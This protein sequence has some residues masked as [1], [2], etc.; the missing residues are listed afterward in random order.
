MGL[1]CPCGQNSDLRHALY[2]D[3]PPR[4]DFIICSNRQLFCSRNDPEEADVLAEG[5]AGQRSSWRWT[6]P[7]CLSGSLMCSLPHEFKTP[8]SHYFQGC[9]WLPLSTSGNP[10]DRIETY[11]K[12]H[13]IIILDSIQD[14]V[15]GGG[16]KQ[17]IPLQ[18]QSWKYTNH[19]SFAI[20]AEAGEMRDRAHL[21]MHVSPTF[22]FWIGL[23][24]FWISLQA[25]R[26]TTPY[27]NISGLTPSESSCKAK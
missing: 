6:G 17:A 16:G 14:Y 21:P 24:V 4:L 8:G 18:E 10:H 26:S 1:T 3:F 12:Y 19:G 11:M 9:F 7:F 23:P 5:A 20:R 25:W 27:L 13:L 22:H 2:V 15:G